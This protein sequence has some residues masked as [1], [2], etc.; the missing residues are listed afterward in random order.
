MKK[1]LVMFAFAAASAMAADVTGYVMDE[2]CST[3]AAMKG[4]EACAAKCIKG[5][6][7]AVLVTEEG[8]IYKIAEQDKVTAHAGHKVTITGKVDGDTINV[9]SVKM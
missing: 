7:K 6:Q 8:K 4:N 3:K 5:G 1:A 9:E 2:S